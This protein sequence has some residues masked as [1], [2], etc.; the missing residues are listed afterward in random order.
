MIC[1]TLT[2]CDGGFDG[3]STAVRTHARHVRAMHGSAV[4]CKSAR[5]SHQQLVHLE[6]P[7]MRLAPYLLC[8]RCDRPRGSLHPA[9]PRNDVLGG[10]VRTLSLECPLDRARTRHGVVPL[11]MAH[12]CVFAETADSHCARTPSGY[13]GYGCAPSL[14][15]ESFEVRGRP[16]AVHRD[17]GCVMRVYLHPGRT[18]RVPRLVVTAIIHT[19]AQDVVQVEAGERIGFCWL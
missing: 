19:R 6:P 15:V 11:K 1:L 14:E 2:R 12:E 9:R 8:T 13:A 10:A 7:D 18:R 16:G 3:S 4:N 5:T 17:G